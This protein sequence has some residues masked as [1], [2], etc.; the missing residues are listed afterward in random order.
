MRV[1]QRVRR[2]VVVLA[3]LMAV[4]HAAPARAQDAS[5][6]Q[7]FNQLISCYY[8]AANGGNFWTM[9]ARGLDCEL[10]VASCVRQA[11]LGR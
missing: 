2:A 8:W 5:T 11:I 6:I 9:W 1:S 7:C 3:L 10:Q 4:L